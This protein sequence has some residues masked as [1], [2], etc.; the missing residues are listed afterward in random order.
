MS[1]RYNPIGLFPCKSPKKTYP[2]HLKTNCSTAT[3]N[4]SSTVDTRIISKSFR[5]HMC[6]ISVSQCS[7]ITPYFPKNTWPSALLPSANRQKGRVLISI[8]GNRV[9]RYAASFDGWSCSLFIPRVVLEH[10][11]FTPLELEYWAAEEKTCS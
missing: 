8:A 10:W 2:N 6:V 11:H 1:S 9:V 5:I 7:I 4:Q 3:T